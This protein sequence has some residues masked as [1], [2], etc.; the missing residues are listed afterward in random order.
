MYRLKP[1]SVIRTR[2]PEPNRRPVSDTQLIRRINN[3]LRTRILKKGR[4]YKDE[5]L[6]KNGCYFIDDTETGQRT[7]HVH[8]WHLAEKLGVLY[9]GEYFEE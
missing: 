8:L 3:A 7:T 5:Y 6:R 2:M 9:E 4:S 1:A